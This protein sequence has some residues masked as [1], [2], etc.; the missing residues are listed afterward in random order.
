[1]GNAHG[2]ACQLFL[3]LPPSPPPPPGFDPCIERGRRG[4]SNNNTQP[5]Y[6]YLHF[7]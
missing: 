3:T 6:R 4:F 5:I 1:M 2:C 7:I